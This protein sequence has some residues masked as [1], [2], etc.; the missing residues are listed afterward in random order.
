MPRMSLPYKNETII[1]IHQL[2]EFN[3]K[4]NKIHHDILCEY[5]ECIDSKHYDINT[6]LSNRNTQFQFFS[7][8]EV[9]FKNFSRALSH[10]YLLKKEYKS[11]NIFNKINLVKNPLNKDFFVIYKW[12]NGK[13]LD[14]FDSGI[15]DGKYEYKDIEEFLIKF[16]HISHK[17][18]VKFLKENAYTYKDFLEKPKDIF[19][20]VELCLL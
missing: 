15:I 8:L 14:C 20:E 16:N 17:K 11:L 5:Y 3:L 19:D 13:V 2:N 9:Y 1:D 10:T 12:K 4:R 6:N 18:V 7:E